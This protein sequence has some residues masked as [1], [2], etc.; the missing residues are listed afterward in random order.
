MLCEYS[1]RSD[2]NNY[3]CQHK[4]VIRSGYNECPTTLVY[5]SLFI[6]LFIFRNNI[7]TSYGFICR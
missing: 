2:N 6:Y 1:Q 3:Y 4:L 5:Q 7:N